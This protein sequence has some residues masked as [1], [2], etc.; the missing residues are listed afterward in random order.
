M[1]LAAGWPGALLAGL[2]GLVFGSFATMLVHRLAAGG[3]LL[4]R[5][6]GCPACGTQLSARDLVPLLSWLA[7]RGRCRH[8]SAAIGWHYPAIEVATALGFL[9][10]WWA[11]GGLGLDF[12]LLAGLWVALVAMG[13]VDLAQGWLPD[14]LQLA[15]ALLAVAWRFALPGDAAAAALDMALGAAVLGGAGLAL[16]WGFRA[17]RGRE[18]FGLGDVKLLAV[19]GLW[20]GLGP[21][22]ALLVLA[23]LGGALLA[24]GWRAAGLGREFP[25]GPP[26][27]LSLYLLLLVPALG[28]LPG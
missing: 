25:L 11:A 1:D 7:T 23:G 8:C 20:L 2:V 17:L 10:A 18:G 5:R 12:A 24:L 28:R 19:A 22:P 3:D 26:L 21:A 9:G 15:A 13:A 4:G 16:R 6:S 14:P 27:A